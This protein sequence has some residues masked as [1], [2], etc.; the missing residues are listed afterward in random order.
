MQRLEGEGLRKRVLACI[1]K[2]SNGKGF[3]GRDKVI[4]MLLENEKT[5]IEVS[6]PGKEVSTNVFNPYATGLNKIRKHTLLYAFRGGVI[7][8]GYN[9]K[10]DVTIINQKELNNTYLSLEREINSPSNLMF[11]GGD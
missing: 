9:G 8:K 7:K 2:E 4:D 1:E 5:A 3:P 6:I 11:Y 10:D